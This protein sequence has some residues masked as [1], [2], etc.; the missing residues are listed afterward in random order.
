MICTMTGGPYRL[1]CLGAAQ[2]RATGKPSCCNIVK[3]TVHKTRTRAKSHRK[4]GAS[5]LCTVSQLSGASSYVEL[6]G[7]AQS[8]G[9]VAAVHVA[10][11]LV[12]LILFL[13]HS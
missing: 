8:S 12:W 7:E 10:A 1:P 11:G 4:A 6:T 5:T 3:C 9:F 13:F 2:L